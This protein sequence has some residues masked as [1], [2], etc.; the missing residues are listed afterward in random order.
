MALRFWIARGRALDRWLLRHLTP[1]VSED[2]LIARLATSRALGG[3]LLIALVLSPGAARAEIDWSDLTFE[4]VRGLLLAPF[5]KGG[6]AVPVVVVGLGVLLVRSRPDERRRVLRTAAR[7]FLVIAS[8]AG[9]L[10]A[11]FVL[12]ILASTNGANGSTLGGLLLIAFGVVFVAFGPP[13]LFGLYRM[14]Y[15]LVRH[16]YCMADCHRLLPPIIGAAIAAISF[17]EIAWGLEGGL[18]QGTELLRVQLEIGGALI[19]ICL[20][21]LEIKRL[22][23]LGAASAGSRY[24]D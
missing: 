9:S 14:C 11:L 8:L 20:S 5:T 7:P 16:S 10:A 1:R 2:P 3:Y 24:E 22:R 13:L 15:L 23:G 19:V 17:A 6:I 21:G 12:M 4:L 18:P